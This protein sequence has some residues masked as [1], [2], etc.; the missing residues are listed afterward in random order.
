MHGS[1]LPQRLCLLL[2]APDS[3]GGRLQASGH[4]LQGLGAVAAAIANRIG[5]CL[6]GQQVFQL[7]MV[8]DGA[9]VHQA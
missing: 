2:L 1:T 4:E 6:I 5:V 3:A 8:D 7:H 9:A